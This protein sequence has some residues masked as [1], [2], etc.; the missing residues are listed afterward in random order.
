VDREV[1]SQSLLLHS[2]RLGFHILG[3]VSGII[4]D[5]VAMMVL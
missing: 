5:V 3:L 1:G 2:F 4:D